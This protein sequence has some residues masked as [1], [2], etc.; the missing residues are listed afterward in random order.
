MPT[1]TDA[2]NLVE[3]LQDIHLFTHQNLKM[4]SNGMKALYMTSWPTQLV[5]KKVTKSGST[6]LPRR[7]ESQTK[8]S[9]VGKAHTM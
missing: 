6:T 3:Q 8:C 5:S 1:T 2:D 9:Q 4:D 7:E